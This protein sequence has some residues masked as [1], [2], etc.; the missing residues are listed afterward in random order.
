MKNFDVREMSGDKGIRQQDNH[1]TPESFGVQAFIP[2][3]VNAKVDPKCEAWSRHLAEFIFNNDKFPPHYHR[4]SNV[5]ER[6]V[7]AQKSSAGAVR[8]KTPSLR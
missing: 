1:R 4:R 2:F 3:K 6:H 7:D 8:F 5:E